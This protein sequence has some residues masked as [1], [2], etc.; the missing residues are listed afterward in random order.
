[1][2][3]SLVRKQD[4]FDCFDLGLSNHGGLDGTDVVL[5]NHGEKRLNVLGRSTKPVLERHHES[6]S[7]SCL[8][9]WQELEHL[10]QSAKQLKHTFFERRSI[11]LL[12]LL[13]EVSDNT[14]RLSQ[15]LHGERSYFVHAHDFRHGRE[16]KNGI[17][18]IAVGLH[19]FDHLFGEFL[20]KNERSNEDICL[21]DI[22]L[23]LCVG[24]LVT[25]FFQQV[26]NTFNGHVVRSGIDTF[27]GSSQ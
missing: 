1:M 11:F 14:L 22:L 10:R 19:N 27:D 8:V 18:V 20:H 12:L 7:I 24:I 16:D 21:F 6:T 9:T 25:Q 13:H 17:Q 4:G 5:S 3:D 26:T 23:K 2:P 15:V